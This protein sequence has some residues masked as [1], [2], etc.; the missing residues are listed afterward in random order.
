MKKKSLL[1]LFCRP[2]NDPVR[3]AKT[4]IET[5]SLCGVNSARLR[6]ALGLETS[7]GNSSVD[8][9]FRYDPAAKSIILTKFFQNSVASFFPK[10]IKLVE[11]CV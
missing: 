8:A 9:F 7:I 6:A 5:Y 2:Q 10:A 3:C 1:W 11:L 4:A